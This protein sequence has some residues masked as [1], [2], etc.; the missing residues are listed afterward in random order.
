M[1][2]FVLEPIQKL[3]RDLRQAATT[4]TDTEA[5]FLVDS[6]YMM[7]RDRI[8]AGHQTRTLQEAQEP[9]QLV[10]WLA[11]NSFVL[12]RN[13]KSALAAYSAAHPVGRWAESITGIGP[14]IS[15]GLLAH[16][17]LTPWR[18]RH[19]KGPKTRKMD[20]KVEFCREGSPC[21]AACARV[22]IATVGKIWR[23]AG[24]DPTV[25]WEPG[26][27]RPWNAALKRL[28][29]LMGESFVKVSSLDS[30]VYG[31]FYLQR[32]AREEAKNAAGDFA[33]Q[34]RV[35]LET[36]RWRRDTST[37]TAYEAG[38]LPQARI[39]LR[40]ERYAVKLFLSH[41]HEV[42]YYHLFKERPPKPYVIAQLGHAD[43]IE[44]PNWPF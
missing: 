12:E 31:K 1:S 44:V 11:N 28:C 17:S 25:K 15:A 42:Y 3:T 19:P 24:L 8:R 20:G 43:V 7:Q 16:V 26:T 38:R 29:W 40:A 21:T 30:D 13:I 2:D 10:G 37:K 18:C 27:K 14:V 32:K 36:K 41:W 22:R 5:R 4:L 23:F 34:A 6:Y 33:E 9:N 39:H 35:A